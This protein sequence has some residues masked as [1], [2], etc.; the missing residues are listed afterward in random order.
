MPPFDKPERPA[1]ARLSMHML[2][3]FSGEGAGAIRVDFSRL[4]GGVYKLIRTITTDAVGRTPEPLFSGDTIPTG[5]YELAPHVGEYYAGR[6]VK[7]G[8]G[9]VFD[10]IPVRFSVFDGTQNYHIPVIFWPTGYTTY[11]G[12]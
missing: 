1:M 3:T 6:G 5:S 9:P 8:D 2:D 7:V 4:E 11:R 12:Q 10:R